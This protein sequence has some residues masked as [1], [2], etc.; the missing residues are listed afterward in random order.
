MRSKNLTIAGLGLTLLLTASLAAAQSLGEIARQLREQRHKEPLRSVRVFTNDNLPPRPAREGPTV[1][2]QMSGTPGQ[3]AATAQPQSDVS[4]PTQPEAQPASPGTG[5]K[6]PEDKQRT[7]DYWQSRFKEVRDQL[8]AAQEQQQVAEDE[9]SLLQIQQA[10]EL[11]SDVQNEVAA[12][13]NAKK[14]ELEARR[15]ATAKAQKAL[16]ALEKEFKESG[17]PDDWSKTE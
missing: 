6:K 13:I 1:A 17:D 10:R 9:L 2:V 7:K 12:K 8:A 15:A 14:P 5:E 11:S 4:T 3:T 16:D